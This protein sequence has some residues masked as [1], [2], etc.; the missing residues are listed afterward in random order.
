MISKHAKMLKGLRMKEVGIGSPENYDALKA[1]TKMNLT[2]LQDFSWDCATKGKRGLAALMSSVKGLHYA[3]LIARYSC[4]YPD[5]D[6]FGN[7]DDDDE[8]CFKTLNCLRGHAATLQHL[9]VEQWATESGQFDSISASPTLRALAPN[10]SRFVQPRELS[11]NLPEIDLGTLDG[12]ANLRSVAVSA[13]KPLS[14][15]QSLTSSELPFSTAQTYILA[16]FCPC[17]EGQ[18]SRTLYHEPTTEAGGVR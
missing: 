1:L 3:C 18:G 13:A 15:N 17:L 4:Y 14:T 10:A 6:E 2:K 7:N 8:E 11:I 16:L 9:R 5:E 12:N